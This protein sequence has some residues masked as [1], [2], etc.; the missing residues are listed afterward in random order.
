MKDRKWELTNDK[1]FSAKGKDSFL[2]V[3]TILSLPRRLAFIPLRR[4]G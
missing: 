1:Y 3:K 4:R 2:K